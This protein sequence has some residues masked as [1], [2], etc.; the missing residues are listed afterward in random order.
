MA[1]EKQDRQ[2]LAFWA[3]VSILIP[4]AIVSGVVLENHGKVDAGDAL[5]PFLLLV[6]LAGVGILSSFL[7]WRPITR[8]LPIGF[9]A[10]FWFSAVYR[11]TGSGY[12]AALLISVVVVTLAFL[13]RGVEELVVARRTAAIAGLVALGSVLAAV[14]G[15]RSGESVSPWRSFPEVTPE[16]RAIRQPDILY[17]VPDRY[18]NRSALQAEFG[19]DNRSFY[20]ELYSRGF[21]YA[22]TASANYPKTFQSMASTLNGA[23]LQEIAWRLADQN[24]DRRQIFR[25]I[26]DN[27]AQE[28]LRKLGYSYL[29]LGSSWEPTRINSHADENYLGYP[30]HGLGWLWRSELERVLWEGSPL[31]SIERKLSVQARV[32]SCSRLKRQFD[33]MRRFGNGGQPVFLFAHLMIPHP[34]V[35]TDENGNCLERQIDYPGTGTSWEDFAHAY[36]SYLSYFNKTIL[37]IID[38]QLRRR[39]LRGRELLVVLQSDEGPFPRSLR[40]SSDENSFVRL[41]ADELRMKMGILNA[42]RLP[43]GEEPQEEM[44]QTPINNWRIVLSHLTGLTYEMKH[45]RSYIFRDSEH[46]YEFEDVTGLLV[47]PE[48]E[49]G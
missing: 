48:R 28:A 43:G 46:L 36:V 12:L 22:E 17:V 31:P 25:L 24:T 47:S 18:G 20:R 42:I 30:R 49:N 1:I 21:S 33:R 35:L 7:V 29:H 9:V 40:E 13:M 38:E 11:V 45:H 16:T 23:Y 10:F 5:R 41:D 37:S 27:L 19:Y 15:L 2:A 26:E 32:D 6:L 39:G 3:V 4:V 14:P 8:A 44:L 34:P